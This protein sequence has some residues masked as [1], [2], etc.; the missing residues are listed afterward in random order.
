MNHTQEHDSVNEKGAPA[1]EPADPFIVD[2][3]PTDDDINPTKWPAKRKWTTIGVLS[4][5]TFMT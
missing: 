2:W 4:F 3:E 5:I 1:E